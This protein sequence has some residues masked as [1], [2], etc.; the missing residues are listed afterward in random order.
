MLW[1]LKNSLKILLLA[2]GGLLLF[3]SSAILFLHLTY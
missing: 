1:L 2:Y 3:Y